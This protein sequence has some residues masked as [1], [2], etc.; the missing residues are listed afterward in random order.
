MHQ[1]E[2][3]NKRGARPTAKKLRWCLG[4]TIDMLH[5]R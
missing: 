4:Y 5:S 2:S 1:L 3:C